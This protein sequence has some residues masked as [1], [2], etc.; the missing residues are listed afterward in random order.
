MNYII[1]RYYTYWIIYRRL[2]NDV[3]LIALL[4]LCQGENIFNSQSRY[5]TLRFQ[6][7]WEFST[8]VIPG[9]ELD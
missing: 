6:I 9:I 1:E 8:V 2:L 5:G 3:V 4:R 7:C